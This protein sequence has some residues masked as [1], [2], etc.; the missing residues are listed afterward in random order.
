VRPEYRGY[1][2][3]RMLLA[4]VEAYAREQ[5]DTV[6]YLSTTPFLHDAIHLYGRCGFEETH[7]GPSELFGTPLLTLVKRCGPTSSVT[8][9]SRESARSVLGIALPPHEHRHEVLPAVE[10]HHHEVTGNERQE[11]AH[12]QKV[13]D[14]RT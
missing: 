10:H 5:G 3:A 12:R 1:G 9:S 8:R 11:A 6:M 14:P 4:Q 2:A 7:D 13:P